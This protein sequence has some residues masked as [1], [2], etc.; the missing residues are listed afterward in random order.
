MVYASAADRMILFGGGYVG[1][2]EKTGLSNETW[3]FDLNTNTWTQM[4]PEVSPPGRMDHAMAYDIESDRVILWGGGWHSP[5]DVGGVWAYDYS[6]DTWEEFESADSPPQLRGAAMLY[7]V[8]ND[9]VLFYAKKE[10]WAYDYN[11]NHWTL[12]SDSPKPYGLLW[13]SMIYDT[14][15]DVVL[16]F[17]GGTN[18]AQWSNKTWIFDP[19]VE[20]WADVTRR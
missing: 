3:S 14:S 13:H 16:S 4:S 12:I 8:L 6:T 1:E 5:I 19:K 18:F 9:R 7:D 10:F 20:E 15:Q 17:G 2:G 11:T